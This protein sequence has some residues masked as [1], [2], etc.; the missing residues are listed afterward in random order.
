MTDSLERANEDVVQEI[1]SLG[2]PVADDAREHALDVRPIAIEENG[3]GGGIS[4][5]ER[6]NQPLIIVSHRF[7]RQSTIVPPEHGRR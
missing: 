4:L 2:L 5:P 3:R 1:V 7:E 6:M